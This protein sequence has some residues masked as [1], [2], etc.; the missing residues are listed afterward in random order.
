[1]KF[2]FKLFVCSLALMLALQC[3]A[4]AVHAAQPALKL[5]MTGDSVYTMQEKLYQL[6]YYSGR[7]DGVFGTGTFN[8]VIRFQTD[9]NLD[10]DGV[11]GLGTM[12]ALEKLS[13][14][15]AADNSSPR[16]L[17]QGMS[18]NGVLE[19]QQKLKEIGYYQGELD[20]AYGSGTRIA[21]VN[22]QFDCNLNVDGIAG[23][24]T[25]EALNSYSA[26]NKPVSRG[27]EVDR[28]AYIIVS[29]A[30]QFLGVPYSWAGSSP[31]GFDCSGFVYYVFGQNGISLPRMADQQFN[32]GVPVSQLQPGDLV[33][34]STYA[35]GPSHAGIYTGNNKFIHASSGTGCVTLTSLSEPYYQA[36]Y[37]GARRVL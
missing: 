9:Y 17:K 21:V 7:P 18:G 28:K 25:L 20:G 11:V 31:S 37:L 24:N 34:Y 33:F 26:T 14:T 16:A 15:A 4:F 35:P 30:N 1:M 23:I 32:T 2:T 3:T 10:T 5:G 22:F 19:L 27:L 36:R 12:Q 8:A 6:G 13:S 29:F